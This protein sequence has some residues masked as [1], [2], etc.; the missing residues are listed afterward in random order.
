MERWQILFTAEV[1]SL[2]AYK[3]AVHM[4][5]GIELHHRVDRSEKA[6]QLETLI[7]VQNLASTLVSQT[8]GL[9]TYSCDPSS[10]GLERSQE[11]S[12]RR[13][14]QNQLNSDTTYKFS[15]TQRS[16]G[17]STQVFTDKDPKPPDPQP[18]DPQLPDPPLNSWP[19]N[20]QLPDQQ[21]E[22][23]KPQQKESSLRKRVNSD[24]S[25]AGMNPVVALLMAGAIFAIVLLFLKCSS[26]N[27]NPIGI[28]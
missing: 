4:M 10:T 9:F 12:R 21:P 16:G 22:D 19:P 24:T 14:S 23:P 15:G 17:T 20:L 7:Y 18:P 25:S 1:T 2:D 26:L 13:I 11:C 8:R 3:E 28:C 5:W 6:C 27:L